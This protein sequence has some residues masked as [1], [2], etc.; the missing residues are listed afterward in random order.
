MASSGAFALSWHGFFSFVAVAMAIHLV[1]RWGVFKGVRSDAIYAIA[2]WAVIGGII[3][4]RLVHVIDEWTFY[5]ANPARIVAVWSGGIALWGGILG[6][7]SGGIV[8]GFVMN[9]VRANRRPRLEREIRNL[10][11]G[12][13][14]SDRDRRKL[15][16]LED[17]LDRNQHLPLGAI[18]DITAPAMLFVQTIGRLGD[19][20]NGEHCAKAVDFPLGFIWTNPLSDARLCA[21]GI[22]VSVQPVIAYE[23]IWNAIALFIIWRLR[24]RLKPNGMV[25]ALY[26]ALYSIGRFAVS[27]AREDDVWVAGL[28]EAHFIA[29]LVLAITVPLLA[30]R[31]RFVPAGD[32]PETDPSRSEPPLQ[33]RFTR[34][35]R[36]RRSHR[37]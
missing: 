27:F 26:L 33:S 25:F 6:G 24:D 30:V 1:A 14:P 19:I 37:R 28:Q 17:E 16:D 4:A 21:N 9:I 10:G 8:S 7:F 35:E 3:G 31:A 5:Q 32:A 15:E 11:R 34:A 22:E 29:L 13:P 12:Q 18:A 36:R 23:M 2:I 20:V